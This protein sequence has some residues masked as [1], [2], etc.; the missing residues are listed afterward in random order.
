[1]WSNG[2]RFGF[3]RKACLRNTGDQTRK[4]SA[5]DGL[6][7]LLPAGVTLQ[8]QTRLSTL[9]DAYKQAESLPAQAA[10]LYNMSSTLTDRAEPSE[11]LKT[12]VVWST[13][14]E[15]PEILLSE[16]QVKSFC[17]GEAVH[18][19]DRIYGRR[20]AY[21]VS[22]MLQLEPMAEKIGRAHV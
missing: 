12:T 5:L 4:I 8:L 6:R 2:E 22:K 10:A 1:M 20:G 11:A 13:G 18:T 19:E 16:I 9:L 21:Y 7:N 14:L 17:A 3:V 15:G